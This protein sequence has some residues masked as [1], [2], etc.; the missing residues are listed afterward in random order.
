MWE[1]IVE[2]NFGCDLLL[3]FITEYREEM[4]DVPV[5]SFQMIGKRYLKGWFI[6][7]LSSIFPFR[8]FLEEGKLVKL[9]RLFRLPRLLKLL[10]VERFKTMLRSFGKG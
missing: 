5:R 8:V 1:F 2:F 6:I 7:D 3:N 9:F 4:S 10:N